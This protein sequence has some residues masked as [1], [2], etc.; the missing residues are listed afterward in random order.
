MPLKIP[1]PQI[2]RAD[3]PP[4]SIPLKPLLWLLPVGSFLAAIYLLVPV[5]AYSVGIPLLLQA[6]YAIGLLALAL[7]LAG[8]LG[9]KIL[10]WLR[11][12]EIGKLEKAL[13]A[14]PIGLGLMAYG[15]LALGLAGILRPWAILLWLAALLV[16]AR[17]E[18]ASLIAGLPNAVHG[19]IRRWRAAGSGPRAVLLLAMAIFGVAGMQ[20]L[21]PPAD[22][23]ALMYHLQAP[24]LFLQAGRI[25]FLPD[26]WQ[27]NSPL[28]IEMLFTIGLAFGSDTFAKL[29]HWFYTAWLCLSAFVF[30][31]RFLEPRRAWLALAIFLGVPSLA[32]WASWA[33]VDSAWALYEF[34]AFYAICC[35]PGS[36]RR[37]WLALA[38]LMAGWALGSKL[39]ALAGAAALGLA[40]LWRERQS[41]WRAL[42]GGAALFS[43]VAALLAAP[44]YLKNFL[45]TGNPFYPLLFG[46]PQWDANRLEMLMVYL[47]SFGAG[48]SW[49]DILLLPFTIFSQN[50]AFGTTGIETPALLFLLALFYPLRRSKSALGL[51]AAFTLLRGL[52]WAFGSQ[53][54]RFL[55]P[56]FPALSILSANVL[57]GFIGRFNASRQRILTV[58][59]IGGMGIAALVYALVGAIP[60]FPVVLGLQSKDSFLRAQPGSYGAIQYIQQ[61]P[62]TARVMF[63]W[64][65]KG[66]YCDERCWPDADQNRWTLLAAVNGDIRSAAGALNE[67]NITHLMLAGD[68]EFFL[69]HDPTGQHQQALAFLSQFSKVCTREIYEDPW[70]VLLELTCEY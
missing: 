69:R 37:G 1:L 7:L 61:L 50:D 21:S 67:M 25:Y 6:F 51:L 24:K 18:A 57:P 30:A 5:D 35:L 66:Y 39:L 8:S 54:T 4:D 26:L 70:T 27:A 41:G 14:P 29:L 20:A 33:N 55:L 43:G 65:G 9:W 45:W 11:L 2:L 62:D 56:V 38:G 47:R 48:Y 17:R 32:V 60:S 19:L 16:W 40:L 63:L 64:D 31:R 23:D 52:L 53:Q 46:G 10:R 59:L 28:T 13:F 44:W 15:V 58:G 3:S 22:Y 36:N 12:P 34:L 68:V 42:I 49:Q